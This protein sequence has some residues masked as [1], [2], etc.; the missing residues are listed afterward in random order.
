MVSHLF[1]LSSATQTLEFILL[2]FTLLYF[3]LLYFTLLYFTL[4]YFTL[5][6]FTLLY[7]TLLYFTLL[8]FTLLYFTLLY[9]TLLYFTLLYFTL[10]YFTLLY[11]TLLYFTLLYFT[12]LYFTLLYFTLL[13]FTLLYFTLLYFTLLY[14]TL[15]LVKI[16][17]LL[18]RNSG[19]LTSTLS[20]TV[21]ASI[22]VLSS[23]H[24]RSRMALSQYLTWPCFPSNVV[25]RFSSGSR[26]SNGKECSPAE[27]TGFG[28]T[29]P[30][31]VRQ[32]KKLLIKIQVC[33]TARD[34]TISLSWTLIYQDRK[35]AKPRQFGWQWK[36]LFR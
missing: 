32:N 3:T 35:E 25:G 19:W 10:L 7:F 18:T 6:Y 33:H 20:S 17:R 36:P 26:N 31:A 27:R 28:P 2:Y 4:L 11:F 5:L 34:P 8:Y 24:G 1:I 29:C 23:F 15:L 21:K 16:N 12:L 14:F 9:F 13:Y 22:T 30:G